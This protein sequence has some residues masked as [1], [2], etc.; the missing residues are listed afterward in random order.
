MKNGKQEKQARLFFLKS[1]IRRNIKDERQHKSG[2]KHKQ[3]NGRALSIY[4]TR[5]SKQNNKK[6]K[7][8]RTPG[9]N[10]NSF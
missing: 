8:A 3:R 6:K 9:N 2:N 4:I 10:K 5:N 1:K 7:K